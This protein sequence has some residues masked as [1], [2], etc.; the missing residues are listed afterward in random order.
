MA[1]N[2]QFIPVWRGTSSAGRVLTEMA[3]EARFVWGSTATIWQYA[4]RA[5]YILAVDAIP[6]R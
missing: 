4:D 5:A 6:I 3:K 1:V 2:C